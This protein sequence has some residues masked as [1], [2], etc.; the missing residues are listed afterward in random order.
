LQAKPVDSSAH[1][2]RTLI[3]DDHPTFR[4]G[5][6]RLLETQPDFQVV[7]EAADGVDVVNLV[8]TL[9]PDVLLLDLSMP[10]RGGLEVLADLAARSSD[11]RPIILAAALSK[12]EMAQAFRLGARGVM[13]KESTT[14]LIIESIRS[15]MKG[16]YWV[17]RENVS[18]LVQLFRRYAAGLSGKDARER[19]GL[20]TRELE[21]VT[22]VV[23]GYSNK[24]I[25]QKLSLSV[26]TVK[27][28]ITS[29][30]D[31]LGVSNRME[32]TLFAISHHLV[33]DL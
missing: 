19:F 26:Q 1:T 31:K 4:Y 6:R 12:S 21:V 25:S 16:E 14:E 3:V 7:G 15:V 17:G 28:H 18:D 11:V 33:D 30:F 24:E 20:S 10:R 2:V 5:L 27:H 8:E 13:L 22:A 9:K 23:A 29:I 32:L